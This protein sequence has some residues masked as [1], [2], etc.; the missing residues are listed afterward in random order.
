MTAVD[1]VYRVHSTVEVPYGELEAY[2]ESPDLPPEIERLETTRQGNQV[3]I[4]SVAADD[5]IGKYTPTATLRATVADARIYEHEGTRSRTEPSTPDGVTPS[6]AVETFANFKGR[7]GTVIKNTAL[8]GPMFTVLRDI[9]H[10]A[11]RGTLTAIVAE[12]GSLA[13]VSIQDGEEVP[14][15]VEV[16]EDEYTPARADSPD[17]QNSR[18]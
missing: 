4:G 3:F 14:A 5:S 18:S 17:W 6:S 12:S 8:R 9:A 13:A 10:L 15:T 1:R 2:L 11:D 16:T 7:L